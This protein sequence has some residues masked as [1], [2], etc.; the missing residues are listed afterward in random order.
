MSIISVNANDGVEAIHKIRSLG[1][2]PDKFAKCL[3]GVMHMRMCRKLC[4]HCK[5]PFQPGPQYIQQLGLP[6]SHVQVLYQHFQPVPDEKGNLPEPCDACSGKGFTGRTGM[7]ELIS[8]DD[9]LRQAVAVQPDLNVIRQLAQ[10]LGHKSTQQ[11][12]I[13]HLA[14]GIT[15]IQELQR[16]M[17]S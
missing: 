14:K 10:Q 17:S 12:G 6:P 7:F 16:A 5:Q 13:L 2:A 11:E 15:S 3:N 8:L 1:V 9:Q 4:E